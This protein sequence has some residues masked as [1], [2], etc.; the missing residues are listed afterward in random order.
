VDTAVGIDLAGLSR[1]TKGC[2]AVAQLSVEDRPRLLDRRLERGEG[3]DVAVVGWVLAHSPRVVAIDA[4][5]TLP[6][7][8]ACSERRCP[9]FGASTWPASSR[10]SVSR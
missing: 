6:H 5:L 3:S 4:P 10:R 1:H 7:A 8:V 2:T 9:R